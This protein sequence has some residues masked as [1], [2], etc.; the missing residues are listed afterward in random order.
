MTGGS[1]NF[2]LWLPFALDGA[3]VACPKCGAAAGEPCVSV[4]TGGPMTSAWRW[5]HKKR[6]TAEFMEAQVLAGR[7]V[8]R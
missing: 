5:T 1:F 6:V 4:K 8:Q 7:R 3:E 2:T